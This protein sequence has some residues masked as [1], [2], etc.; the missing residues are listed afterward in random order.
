M[1]PHVDSTFSLVDGIPGCSVALGCF[2][3][4]FGISMSGFPFQTQSAQFAKLGAFLK[5]WP[6]ST[7][8]GTNFL[9]KFGI[10]MV[11]KSVFK[12]IEIVEIL[13]ST[14]SIPIQN[15]VFSEVLG[16]YLGFNAHLSQNGVNYLHVY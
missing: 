15:L 16:K 9:Q 3:I 13:E 11:T 7:Q 6:K 5:I 4:I 10:V 2:F 8:F 12:G 1:L 14:L